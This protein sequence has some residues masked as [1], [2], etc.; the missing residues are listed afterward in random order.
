MT[1]V[2]KVLITGGAGF[3]GYHMALRLIKEGV[4][5]SLIDIN[6]QE[7]PELEGKVEFYKGDIRNPDI[8]EKA[9]KD[10]D[11]VIHAAAALPIQ[12]SFKTI[13]DI[14]V[15]GTENVLKACLKNGVK[16][17]VYISSTAI[18]GIPKFHPIY[19]TSKIEPLGNYGVSKFEAEK[20][21]AKY[22]KKGL[23]VAI[24]RPKTFIGPGRL[25]VFEILFDWIKRGKKIYIIGSGKNRYQL[26]AVSDLV[27][28][29]WLL[30]K[31]NVNDTFNVGAKE[32]DTLRN[33]LQA[34]LDFAATKSKLIPLPAKPVQTTLRFLELTG[35][36]PL[37]QW[38]YETMN[39]DSFVDISKAEKAL[40]WH[41]KKSNEDMLI[42]T[43]DWYIKHYKNYMNKKTGLTHKVPW[44]Q[45]ILKLIRLFS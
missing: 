37:V 42:E 31:S 36:S 6:N 16:R 20:V 18:Y 8:M 34:L 12:K 7:E 45:K 4:K 27:D 13:W 40:K 3:F 5:V 32:F 21:C 14:N 9:C 30:S 41:P 11:V 35:L 10:V 33:D 38:Q 44:D 2:K 26:L 19:E 43:Y 1:K 23:N 15:N 29:V 25:G 39:K 28:F 24:V 17:V 22:V